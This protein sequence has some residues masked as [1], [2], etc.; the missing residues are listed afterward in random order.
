MAA[1]NTKVNKAVVI[2]DHGSYDVLKVQTFAIP[3]PRAGEVLVHVKAAGLN[4]A[5]GL[6][7]LLFVYHQLFRDRFDRS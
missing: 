4:F 3:E 6:V 1:P 2:T 5:E 7:F